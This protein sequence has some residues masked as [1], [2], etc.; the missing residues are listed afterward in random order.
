MSEEEKKIQAEVAQA[1]QKLS[2]IMTAINRERGELEN[3]ESNK[4]DLNSEIV[5]L[6]DSRD[7]LK[8]EIADFQ[9]EYTDSLASAKEEV[10]VV[11]LE[12]ENLVIKSQQIE[13]E[14]DEKIA[15]F[16]QLVVDTQT[17][18][19]A[20]NDEAEKERASLKERITLSES[21]LELLAKATADMKEK[22]DGLVLESDNTSSTISKI[23]DVLKDLEQ[24][25]LVLE[26]S[27]LRQQDRLD[28]LNKAIGDAEE[29]KLIVDAENNDLI[30][31]NEG[32]LAGSKILQEQLDAQT[33]ERDG[34]IR[35]KF[36]LQKDREDLQ[37]LEAFIKEKYEQAGVAFK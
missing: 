26:E 4:N 17:K 10:E 6:S 27:V 14:N 7:S 34:F 16:D 28:T 32:L 11:K 24:N 21:E 22:R 3:L 13:G 20:M 2:D 36:A 31:L 25:K 23:K 33:A 19:A 29:K 37:N 5:S 30:T 12:L 9:S 35:E 1:Q 8:K 18:I 15:D